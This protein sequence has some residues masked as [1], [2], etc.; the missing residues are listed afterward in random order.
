M[1][2]GIADQTTAIDVWCSIMKIILTG[3]PYP[4]PRV[5]V[6][7]FGSYYSKKHQ[8]KFKETLFQI[9]SQVN[10]YGW[11]VSDKPIR[12]DITTVSPC[13][14]RLKKQVL[15]KGKRLY[16]PT[17]PDIDNYTKYILDCITKSKRIWKDDKQVVELHQKDFYGAI[18]ENP[19]TE[20]IIQELNIM[21]DV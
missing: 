19:F 18:G 14:Q 8:I 7:K 15:S 3:K 1:C 10:Y 17:I 9:I 6:G 11:Q 21:G 16:K 2:E 12:I 4:Q 13:P 20:I 5:Q